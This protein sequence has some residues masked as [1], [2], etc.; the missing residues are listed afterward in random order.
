[1][2]SLIS[3]E[4]VV[5]IILFLLAILAIVS[6][7]L[8]LK[9]IF[10]Q[11]KFTNTYQ[12]I[13]NQCFSDALYGVHY[14][15]KVFVC[16][17]YFL[18]NYGNGEILCVI[19]DILQNAT[20][21]V[22][23]LSIGLI[24][25]DRYLTICTTNAFTLKASIVIP[26][27]WIM[28]IFTSFLNNINYEMLEFFTEFDKPIGCRVCMPTEILFFKKRFN[29]LIVALN[30]LIAVTL[31]SFAYFMVIL[32][33]HARQPIGSNVAE[34]KKSKKRTIY[35]LIV[36]YISFFSFSCPLYLTIFYDIRKPNIWS[37]NER[38]SP[39]NWFW[40]T[41]TLVVTTTIINPLIMVFF[42]EDFKEECFK[43]C[44]IERK[45]NE[46]ITPGSS[47]KESSIEINSL[48]LSAKITHLL[49]VSEN[50]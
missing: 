7:G 11:R 17:T 35:M 5:F 22:S 1:M 2:H 45:K 29:V 6:N 38:K 10:T 33:V 40:F 46:M 16:S 47:K 12:L 44:G 15:V 9:F 21:C 50:L 13:A 36:M 34:M 20:F 19:F 30:G 4:W 39:G 18:K 14:F 23:A 41:W 42:N 43:M 24:A 3:I 31:S 48:S 28:G 26:L 27:T 32:K 37:C 25:L 49:S 8:V